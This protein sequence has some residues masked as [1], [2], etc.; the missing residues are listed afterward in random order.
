MSKPLKID[1][2]MQGAPLVNEGWVVAEGKNVVALE[3][4]LHSKRCEAGA[5]TSGGNPDIPG[6][7]IDATEGSLHLGTEPR[8]T[9]TWIRFP[10]YVDWRVWCADIARYTLNVCLVKQR[11]ED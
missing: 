8:E 3:I 10:E 5:K 11:L 1:V 4:D 9:P 2:I 6:L 7:F